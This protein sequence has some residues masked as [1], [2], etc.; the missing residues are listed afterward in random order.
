MI[1]SSKMHTKT[2]Y[3]GFSLIELM[4]A[5]AVLAVIV[6]IALPSYNNYVLRSA[7]AEAKTALSNLASIQEQFF[8]NSKSYTNIG[9]LGFPTSTENDKYTI[10][11]P[12]LTATTYTLRAVPQG[13]Q[14]AD[15]DCAQFELDHLGN[16]TATSNEC[17]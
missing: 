3:A 14:A 8:L 4:V 16:K 12:T 13:G 2:G 11:I 5:I 6:A 7:R 9:T 17:W 1:H 10:S 15:T